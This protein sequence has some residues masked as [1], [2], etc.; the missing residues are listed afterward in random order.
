MSDASDPEEPLGLTIDELA[1]HTRV[2]SRTIRFYQSAGALPKPEIRG[3]KAFYTEA[4]IE[5]LALI[6][7]LQD[8]GLR[9]RAIRDI[10]ARIDKG[11]L[12]LG[13]WLG[14]EQQ[15]AEPWTDESPQLLADTELSELLAGRRTGLAADLARTGVIRR[16][17]ASWLVDRPS[18]LHTTLALLDA[19]VEPDVA[20]KGQAVVQ[21]H[22]ARLADELVALYVKS[23]G[24]G[25]GGSGS[26][27]DV[28]ASFQALRRLAVDSVQRTFAH[29][30]QRVLRDTV[31][32]G[33]AAK[34]AR[35]K[36]G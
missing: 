31:T 36:S 1:A 9:I 28:G 4:H 22:L 18:Q 26:A 33:A 24:D 19:G 35:K 23:A 8:R 6:G 15:L 10:T 16:Q 17:G 25:F 21:R 5:R 34:L 13:E 11:E 20:A 32:S 29:E 3:R 2:P 27:D 14:L 12:A 30:M 7:Q